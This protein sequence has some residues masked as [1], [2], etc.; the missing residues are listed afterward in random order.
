MNIPKLTL[1]CLVVSSTPSS[2]QKQEHSIIGRPKQS[3][4]KETRSSSYTLVNTPWMLCREQNAL[5]FLRSHQI[6]KNAIRIHMKMRC[7]YV[8]K[9]KYTLIE[10]FGSRRRYDAFL[11]FRKYMFPSLQLVSQ[12]IITYFDVILLII[13]SRKPQ[14]T[15][16]K[17]VAKVE[18][19][20]LLQ[21][22]LVLMCRFSKKHHQKMF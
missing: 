20:I 2:G 6:T 22:K 11:T 5:H 13:I 18:R 8:I 9:T 19:L 16:K 14:F 17:Y 10:A 21:Q 15:L 7:K 1:Q 3:L 12:I 4:Q